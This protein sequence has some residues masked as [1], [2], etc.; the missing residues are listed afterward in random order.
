MFSLLRWSRSRY[1]RTGNLRLALAHCDFVSPQVFTGAIPFDDS[2]TEV[3]SLAIM[4]GKRP[5]RPSHSS[6]TD[7]LWIFTQR[8]WDQDPRL[9]PKVSEVF[10][11]LG[12]S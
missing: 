3:A 10:D 11:I 9:R 6:F 2:S 12:G 7:G 8:G 1:S 4:S 5:C